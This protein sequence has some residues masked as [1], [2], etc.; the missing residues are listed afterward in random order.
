[1][2]P[3]REAATLAEWLKGHSKVEVV[4]RDRASYYA[5]GVSMG[6]PDA[7]QVADR[8]HLLVRRLTRHSIPITDGKGDKGSLWVNGLPGG[9]SQRE[10]QHAA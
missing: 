8:W 6:A 7:L 9:E 2:L 1:M 10:K 4:T 5:D 3:G